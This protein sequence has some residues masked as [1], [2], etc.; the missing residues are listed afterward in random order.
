ML[1]Q[2]QFQGPAESPLAV[3]AIVRP[4]TYLGEFSANWRT[5]LGACLGQGL[6]STLNHYTMN[7]YAPAIVAEFGWKKSEFALIGTMSLVSVILF[8]LVGRMTDRRGVFFSVL[9]G[10]IALPIGLLATSMVTGNIVV[11]FVVVLLR[12]SLSLCTTGV[13]FGKAIVERFDRARGL[14]LS[15]TLTAAPL[16]ATLL[17]PVI[18]SIIDIYG[19]RAAYRAQAVLVAVGGL[20]VVVLLS[21]HR[22][23]VQAEASRLSPE[24]VARATRERL[25]A[26]IK[27]PVFIFLALG[28]LLCKIPDVLTSSQLKF[29][30][31]EKGA[32]S[33]FA[34]SL[35]S[36][37][38]LS[39][40][41]GRLMTGYAID[42]VAPHV[43]ALV[44]VTLPAIGL[45]GL[46]SHISWM[47]ILA[48]GVML[49]GFAQGAE[50]DVGAILVA[51]KFGYGDYSFVYG[52]TVAVTSIGLTVGS[53][54]LSVTLAQTDRYDA[55]LLIAAAAVALAAASFF[56]TGRYRDLEA[57]GRI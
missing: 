28:I 26:I 18:N 36:L 43:V 29:V 15:L 22:A 37:F 24:P 47:W 8:P 17:V 6:G 11:F 20:V 19:W 33:A 13:V 9:I 31:V 34:A 50:G 10:F 30:L 38:M 12:D 49:L 55:F 52:L 25:L 39:V 48:A 7:L 35:I 57:P 23:P 54:L 42:R 41:G 53:L 44:V 40:I 5:L 14:A 16:V 32:T 46:A 21:Q 27:E 51:R 1:Q 45:L 56:I 2:G 4:P 3:E